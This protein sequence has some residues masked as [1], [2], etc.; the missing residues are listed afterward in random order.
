MDLLKYKINKYIK[1]TNKIINQFGGAI[2]LI[3][4]SEQIFKIL[5][6]SYDAHN[7][8]NI[9][10]KLAS[11]TAYDYLLELMCKSAF[12]KLTDDETTYVNSQISIINKIYIVD[13]LN[14][15]HHLTDISH[16]E[17]FRDIMRIAINEIV[18][19][20]M[21]N[22]KNNNTN[23]YLLCIYEK[24]AVDFYR[25]FNEIA[26]ANININDNIIFISDSYLDDFT[27]WNLSIILSTYITYDNNFNPKD[28]KVQ[29]ISNDAQKLIDPQNKGANISYKNLY[30]E[31]LKENKNIYRIKINTIANTYLS[32][33]FENIKNFIIDYCVNNP[34]SC[35]PEKL[36]NKFNNIP[37]VGNVGIDM[38]NKC[39]SC[40]NYLEN[41]SCRFGKIKIDYLYA[42]YLYN[43][44]QCLSPNINKIELLLY[45]SNDKT[46]SD[47]DYVYEYLS[48]NG[49]THFNNYI[50]L[51]DSAYQEIQEMYQIYRST[52]SILNNITREIV[53]N[54]IISNV[55]SEIEIVK[56]NIISFDLQYIYDEIESYLQTIIEYNKIPDDE[57]DILKYSILMRGLLSES[58]IDIKSA[59]QKRYNNNRRLI[60]SK[61]DIYHKITQNLKNIENLFSDIEKKITKIK[62]LHEK[63]LSRAKDEEYTKFVGELHTSISHKIIRYKEYKF[64]EPQLL[65]QQ[66]QS[67]DEDG[68]I[69]RK[70]SGDSDQSSRKKY[71][72]NNDTKEDFD[73]ILNDIDFNKNILMLNEYIKCMYVYI[74]HISD[75]NSKYILLFA[76][77]VQA[78]Y[79]FTNARKKFGLR[80]FLQIF[81]S[82]NKYSDNFEYIKKIYDELISI[83]ITLDKS[84]DT[85]VWGTKITY[86]NDFNR[87]F[88]MIKYIQNIF[89][90]CE[91]DHDK[92]GMNPENL[93]ISFKI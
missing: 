55:R 56:N 57:R 82:L 26:Q 22:K 73:N 84:I 5:G 24:N 41:K 89:F 33:S 78:K 52:L 23:L 44:L 38:I 14:Y 27:Y 64:L 28:S 17:L 18:E 31:L 80:C 3:V 63:L 47:I 30:T 51:A 20:N 49:E 86:C 34:D 71:N 21:Y 48:T 61:N 75:T 85:F 46:I 59:K 19:H 53:S 62:Q 90:N 79:D 35:D 50:K 37:D 43:Y 1:K 58:N 65:N 68:E 2:N 70:R 9:G 76:Q 10:H 40:P 81:N 36:K 83:F 93:K 25:M 13:F 15:A 74:N 69:S 7:E 32:V 67:M 11:N 8:I 87:Y 29:L 66:E 92:C 42:N 91:R 4:P 88:A 6:V 45:I 77:N 54:E 60:Q 16:K 72:I 39:S 12:N